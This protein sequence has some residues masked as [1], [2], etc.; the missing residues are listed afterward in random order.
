M[1][2]GTTRI[3]YI[4]MLGI[5]TQTWMV[6]T[7]SVVIAEEAVVVVVVVA[8]AAAVDGAAA[9]AAADVAAATCE[10]LEKGK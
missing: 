2:D 8:A 7:V 6:S 9:V 1:E 10:A 3:L 4:T 5:L